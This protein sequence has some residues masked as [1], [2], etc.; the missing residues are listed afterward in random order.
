MTVLTHP[1]SREEL[2]RDQ[3]EKRREV[4]LSKIAIYPYLDPYPD[5][6]QDGSF[7]EAVAW[8]GNSHDFVDLQLLYAVQREA[9]DV[10]I[11]RDLGIHRIARRLGLVDRVFDVEEALNEFPPEKDWRSISIPLE[12]VELWQI[13]TADSFF[14][15]LK[16]DYG[17]EFDG[18]WRRKR[19]EGRKAI[20]NRLDDGR[21]GAM[22]MLKVEG[23]SEAPSPSDPPLGRKRRLKICTF[24]VVN[25]GNYLG[26]LF[27]KLSIQRAIEEGCDE[28][29]F[30]H[31]DEG[32]DDP[33]LVLTKAYG[34]ELWGVNRGRYSRDEGVYVKWLRPEGDV[35][36]LQHVEVNRIFYPSFYD[37]PL[38]SKAIV[39][40][41][42]TYH[43][44]LFGNTDRCQSTLDAFLGGF[45]PEQNTIRK[46]YIC[47]SRTKLSPGDVLLF[48]CSRELGALTTVGVVE[49]AYYGVTKSDTI[50]QLVTRRTVYSRRE[51]EDFAEGGATV[52]LFR[53]CFDLRFRVPRETLINELS[54]EIPQSIAFIRE[55]AYIGIA[56][57]AGLDGRFTIH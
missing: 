57:R 49:T 27:I 30:T 32:P 13:D 51:I 9:V 56:R 54:T 10:L 6:T 39:P 22:L 29:Y 24:K 35:L 17:G 16:M 31:F 3:D 48:Y 52:I 21:L 34:F 12:E 14:D 38:V 40:I 50:H 18:W 33:L 20:I 25:N 43:D 26:E 37:G 2:S 4:V 41:L 53:H 11:T 28:I 46:A 5:F 45:I 15:D 44:R 36:G 55:D 42:P 8:N 7:T 19:S 23:E 47:R 1:L